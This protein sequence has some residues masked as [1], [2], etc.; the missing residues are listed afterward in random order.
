M[1]NLKF[2][3]IPLIAHSVLKQFKLAYRK[4]EFLVRNILILGRIPLSI[5]KGNERRTLSGH[6]FMINPECE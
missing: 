4:R 1:I 6:L 5:I 2:F 3:I